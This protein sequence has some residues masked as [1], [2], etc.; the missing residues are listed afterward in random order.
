M[1]KRVRFETSSVD[2]P[3]PVLWPPAGPWWVTAHDGAMT[4]AFVVAYLHEDQAV[5]GYWP[6]AENITVQRV[7]DIVFTDRFPQPEWWPI[8][9]TEGKDDG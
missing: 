3:R 4:K 5:H 2:D 7:D 1:W 8:R 9:D 6:E